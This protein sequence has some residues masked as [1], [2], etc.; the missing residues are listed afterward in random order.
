MPPTRGFTLSELVVAMAVCAISLAVAA[1]SF[2]SLL[3]S[4]RLIGTSNR[5]LVEIQSAR[6]LAVHSNNRATICGSDDGETCNGSANWSSGT[7]TF[8]D[9]N[10]NGR[11]D[12][13]EPALR[14]LHLEELHG[15]Q[16]GTSNGRKSLAFTPA[17]FTAGTNLTLHICAHNRREW[18]QI[19][20]NLAGR[21][22]VYRPL[23]P[24]IC[25]L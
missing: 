16:I 11:R 2:S 12:A 14:R 23:E 25:A 9:N 15:L 6:L 21:S 19:I 10:R 24:S 4:Q 13:L 8:L 3:A 1:P 7:L 22:R 20:V 5:V 17:G 18:R